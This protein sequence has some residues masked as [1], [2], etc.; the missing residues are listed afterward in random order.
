MKK[1]RSQKWA[2]FLLL[3]NVASLCQMIHVVVDAWGVA[4]VAFVGPDIVVIWRHT[5]A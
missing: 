5:S 1:S 2:R 3:V 4:E